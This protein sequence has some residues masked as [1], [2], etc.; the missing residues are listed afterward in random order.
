VLALMGEFL[1][2]LQ[3]LEAADFDL[4]NNETNSL[5]RLVQALQAITGAIFA[6]G[7]GP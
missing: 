4:V 1:D 3:T 5:E 7:R 2:K 6:S